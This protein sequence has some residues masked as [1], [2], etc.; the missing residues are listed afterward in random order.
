MQCFWPRCGRKA[1]PSAFGRNTSASVRPMATPS[2]FG[3]SLARE[4]G[5]EEIHVVGE[6]C[7]AEYLLSG[8]TTL[9]TRPQAPSRRPCRPRAGSGRRSH[10]VQ[11]LR[12]LL[13]AAAQQDGETTPAVHP[14]GGTAADITAPKAQ[15]HCATRHNITAPSGTISLSRQGQYHCPARDNLTAISFSL[16]SAP[17]WCRA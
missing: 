2:A 8:R 13:S 10:R 1:T 12:E 17:P 4:P 9:T 15:Y 16:S 3:S 7:L 6:S 11:R 14:T 5:M